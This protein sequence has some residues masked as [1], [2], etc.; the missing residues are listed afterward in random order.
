MVIR[1]LTESVSCEAC[2]NILFSGSWVTLAILSEML[3]LVYKLSP[4]IGAESSVKCL[5]EVERVITYCVKNVPGEY[6]AGVSARC[7]E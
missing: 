7:A 6:E 4:S 5:K 3:L 1:R 2:K